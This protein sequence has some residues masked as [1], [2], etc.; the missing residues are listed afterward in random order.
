M[1]MVYPLSVHGQILELHP[2]GTAFWQQ[3]ST[4]IVSDLHFGK[5]SHFRKH[6]SAVPF[7][8]IRK[9]IEHLEVVLKAFDPK[10]I[11]FL[12][13]LFHSHLNSEWEIFE[14]WVL[15]YSKDFLL[16]KGNHDII[17]PEN[18]RRIGI[19]YIDRWESGPFTFTHEPEKISESFNVAGHIHPAVQLVGSGRQKL[20][21]PCFLKRPEQLILPAFGAF[22]G[23]HVLNP[24]PDDVAYVLAEGEIIPFEHRRPGTFK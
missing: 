14:Q 24:E 17:P 19:R 10:K 2:L 5:I 12:G 8:A 3:E 9:N 13:D 18:Y 6:G 22:T 16:I 1:S 4:L 15:S 23:T 7:E 20:K 21:L 11:C